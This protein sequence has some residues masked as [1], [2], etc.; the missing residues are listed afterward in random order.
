MAQQTR[1]DFTTGV[2][3]EIADITSKVSTNLPDNTSGLITPANVRTVE[4][5]AKDSLNTLMIN[6]KDSF[7][8]ILSDTTDVVTEGASNLYF[9]NARARAAISET[10]TGLDYNSTTGVFSLTAGYVIPTTATAALWT[11]AYDNMINSASFNSGTNTITLTQQDGGTVT[12]VINLNGFTTDNLATVASKRYLP[13]ILSTISDPAGGGTIDAEARTA[14]N[15]I[16]DRL[17]SA[18]IIL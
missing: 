11:A 2:G 10:V 4:N 13:A 8:N 9:T 3:T 5:D 18:E 1:V 17:Q 7:Y 15:T 14:I 16:I 12:V 6:V